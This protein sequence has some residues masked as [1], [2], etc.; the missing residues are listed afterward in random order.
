MVYILQLRL[1]DPDVA[2]NPDEYQKLAK[3]IAELEEVC[4]EKYYP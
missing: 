2:S 4:V 1:A 3:S